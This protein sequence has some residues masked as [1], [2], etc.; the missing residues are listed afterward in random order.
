LVETKIERLG[1]WAAPKVQIRITST[2]VSPWETRIIAD[3]C[4]LPGIELVG[5]QHH[6][7]RRDL[8][9]SGALEVIPLAILA[10][11]IVIWDLLN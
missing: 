1:L 10:L 6:Q 8:P 5:V 4:D 7:L 3:A 9:V 11:C 2:N